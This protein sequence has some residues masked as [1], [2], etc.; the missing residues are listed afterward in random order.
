[1]VGSFVLFILHC[2]INISNTSNKSTN[3]SPTSPSIDMC[4]YINIIKDRH[5]ML[6]CWNDIWWYRNICWD[7][8]DIAT[9]LYVDTPTY[10]VWSSCWSI[11]IWWRR[12]IWSIV[13]SGLAKKFLLI[14]RHFFAINFLISFERVAHISE[15]S[16][17][18]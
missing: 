16:Y 10:D 3:G 5:M 6:Q 18:Y 7:N 12:I 4:C 8:V 2:V 1:M 15:C 17:T 14:T 13:V 11:D 9:S